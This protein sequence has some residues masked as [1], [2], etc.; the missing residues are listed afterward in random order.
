M[1]D[2]P[3]VGEIRLFSGADLPDGWAACDGQSL[4]PGQYPLLFA[5]IGTRYGD[6][7]QTTFALPEMRGRLPVHMGMGL[8]LAD[9]GGEETHALTGAQM[10]EHSHA[11]VASAN[12]ANTTAPTSALLATTSSRYGPA[13][14]LTTLHPSTVSPAGNGQVHENRQPYTVMTWG[15]ALDGVFPTSG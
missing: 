5:L 8:E 4:D 7:G 12:N 3:F 15:I 11:H 1:G 14:A 2:G 13:D 9:T 6:D 10:A